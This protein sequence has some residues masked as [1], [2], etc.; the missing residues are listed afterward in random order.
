[1]TFEAK[2]KQK[3]VPGNLLKTCWLNGF[4]VT[5]VANKLDRST[6]LIYRAV[7]FPDSYPGVYKKI[8]DLLPKRIEDEQ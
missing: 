6:T 3:I 5:D 4:S 1:M 8:S 7:E 2:I